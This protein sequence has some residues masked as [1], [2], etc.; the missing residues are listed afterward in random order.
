MGRPKMVLPWGKSTIIAHV[1]GKLV[2]AG[3]DEI[4]VISGGTHDELVNAL[5]GLPVRIIYHPGYAESEMVDSL[6]LGLTKASHEAEAALIV[7]GDQP[8]IQ[9]ETI[10]SVLGA[11]HRSKSLLVVPSFQHHRGHPW[12]ID[13]CLWPDVIGIQKPRTLRHFLNANASD[14]L[15]VEIP[16]DT[17]LRDLDT[18]EDYE[19][20]STAF[21]EE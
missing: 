5:A 17:I 9:L 1:V 2:A 12:L 13:R 21:N 14:I 18:P 20:E 10:Q 8:Q 3:L 15:Y 4:L 16:N 6:M 7:L 19:R 11:Y